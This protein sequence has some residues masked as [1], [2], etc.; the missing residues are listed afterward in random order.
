[1]G[2]PSSHQQDLAAAPSSQAAAGAQARRQAMPAVA[3][4]V[5]LCRA[6]YDGVFVDVDAA[7]ATAQAARREHVQV[8][9]QQGEAAARQWHRRNAVRCTF[10][11]HEAGRTVGLAT[12]W[13]NAHPPVGTPPAKTHG[14]NS[15]PVRAPVAGLGKSPVSGPVDSALSGS[16][17]PCGSVSAS[18]AAAALA[19]AP[20]SGSVGGA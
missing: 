14:G 5:D 12:P 9:E 1:M 4:F 10:Y 16:A 15:A 7:M 6:A 2:H 17:L 20:G 8:L 18:G 19:L 3:A 11:A 13:T